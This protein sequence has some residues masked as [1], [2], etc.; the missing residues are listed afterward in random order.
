MSASIKLAP[1]S[2]EIVIDLKGFKDDMAKAAS[3]G[4][5]EAKKIS[6]ELKNVTKIGE[7]LSSFGSK[8]TKYVTAPLLGAGAAMT[9]MAVSFGTDFAKVSTLLDESVVDFADY[10]KELLSASNDSK[11]AVNE[12]S[13][14]VYGSIS[15]GVDQTEAIGFTTEAMKLAKG[16][17]TTGAKAVDVMTTAINGYKLSTEDATK[18]S[19][20]LI[21]TQNLGKTTVD[22]LASSM[23]AVIP[24][25]NNANFAMNELSTSYALMTKNGIATSE[26]GTYLKSMLS[27]LTKSGSITDGVLRELTGKGFAGLKEEGWATSDIFN[28]L[29]QYAQDN[30]KSLKDLF[31]SVEAGSAALILANN[32]GDD[33]NE[34]LSLMEESAGAT[35][36][37][38]DKMDATP[39]ERMKGAW[40]KVKNAGI[41]LGE[42]LVPL[43]EKTADIINNL[44]DEFNSLTDE[45]KENILKWGGL[46]IA[47]GPVLK[48]VGNG[49]QSFVTLK[50]TISGVSKGLKTMSASTSVTAKGLDAVKGAAKIA[51]GATG[52]GGMITSLGGVVT[53]AAPFALGAVAVGAAAYGVHKTLSKDVIPT[54]DLFA[55]KVTYTTNVVNTGYNS[56]SATTTKSVTKISEATATAVQA[57][58]DMDDETTKALYNQQINHSV[59]SQEIADD[60]IGKFQTMGQTIKDSQQTNFEEMTTDLTNFFNNNS[61]LTEE[62]EAEILNKVQVAHQERQIT[63]DNAMARITEIYQTAKNNNVALTQQ[64]MDEVAQLQAQMRDNAINTMSETEAEAAV[65]RER[66]KDYQGRLT[67]EMASE[68]ITNANNAR[69]G[70]IKAANEKYEE[71]IKQAARL[72]EA[73]LITE[74]EYNSMVE[75]ARTTRDD[76]I[77]AAEEACEGVKTEIA[78]A[79]PGI[80]SEV[81]F[82]TGKIKTAYDTLKEKLSGFFSWLF[83]KNQEAASS[84]DNVSSKAK[85]NG[86]HYNGLDYVPF[87]G[88]IARLHKGER[89][90][91][92]EENKV[93]QQGGA[94]NS[95]PTTISVTVPLSVNGRDIVNETITLHEQTS[96]ERLNLTKRGLLID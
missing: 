29:N 65:I 72:K 86:S 57:Y 93:Y 42:S 63:I 39:A 36:S 56:M 48:V 34:M 46:A 22:E 79:T 41:E 75:D 32:N 50:S 88:Y 44:V 80:E 17:F 40:N 92:A 59:I 62:R 70:E 78:N 68:M 54:V 8:M 95:A 2:T 13:E 89:V 67:A 1:L 60:M 87:D 77:T 96:G 24:V 10:K 35:Q 51:S 90:L 83:G 52:L 38:F 15:A 66:M 3:I 23:G 19:D 11:V 61:S 14:A 69:D 49:V 94:S 5:S 58:M 26:A 91:T 84:T 7:N 20:Y 43:F 73:G 82:Q 71:V 76:Q 33:F 74:E 28:L 55:D 81:N 45:Q 37:A 21:T 31:G 4:V 18:I 64:E 9:G 16:G 25:A 30:N 53:A 6:E 47:I 85:T 12:F 27:E